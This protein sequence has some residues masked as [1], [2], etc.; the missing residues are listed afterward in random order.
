VGFHSKCSGSKYNPS[1]SRENSIVGDLKEGQLS[2]TGP[3]Y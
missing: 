2:Q 3:L 1:M